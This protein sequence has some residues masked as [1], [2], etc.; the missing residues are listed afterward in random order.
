MQAIADQQ[1][2]QRFRPW[3]FL[4][5]ALAGT[6]QVFTE[7][8]LHRGIA[9]LAIP[10]VLEMAMESTFGIVDAFW[11][12]GLGFNAM[13]AVGITEALIVLIFSVALGLSMA[14]T[15]TVARRIGEKDS[16]GASIAAVQAIGCDFIVSL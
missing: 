9:L 1:H 13:A 15:A 6:Q 2:H 4:R 14:A 8:S 16:E 12:A 5:E 10:T 3:R 11:V 7:G